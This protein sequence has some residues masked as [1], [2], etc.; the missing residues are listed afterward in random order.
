[1]Y[2]FICT[3]D[4]LFVYFE[5]SKK[6]VDEYEYFKTNEWFAYDYVESFLQAMLESEI[7]P[8][9]FIEAFRESDIDINV[10]RSRI[11][12][13]STDYDNGNGNGNGMLPRFQ[14]INYDAGRRISHSHINNNNNNN[15]NNL[16]ISSIRN[17]YTNVN[18]S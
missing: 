10:N 1:M 5:F 9:L 17:S 14:Q 6:A 16:S 8:D 3:C 11:K 12:L 4:D 2:Y 13:R 18:R 15:N 7:I